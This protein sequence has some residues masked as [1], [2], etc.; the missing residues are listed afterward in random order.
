MFLSDPDALLRRLFTSKQSRKHARLPWDNDDLTGRRATVK[1]DILDLSKDWEKYRSELE[2]KESAEKA[3]RKRKKLEQL[4]AK[5][6][7]DSTPS[8]SLMEQLDSSKTDMQ[9]VTNEA[10]AATTS[11]GLVGTDP[12]N[13]QAEGTSI[14]LPIRSTA[15]S[16][17]AIAALKSRKLYHLNEADPSDTVQIATTSKVPFTDYPNK[18]VNG[19]AA[20]NEAS[21]IRQSDL[22]SID[23]STTCQFSNHELESRLNS[24]IGQNNLHGNPWAPLMDVRGEDYESF[25]KQDVDDHEIVTRTRKEERTVHLKRNSSRMSVTQKKRLRIPST[26]DEASASDSTGPQLPG[27]IQQHSPSAKRHKQHGRS[28]CKEDNRS[29]PLPKESIRSVLRQSPIHGKQSNLLYSGE[30]NSAIDAHGKHIR[31][32]EDDKVI[33]HVE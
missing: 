32:G 12:A 31:F 5:P 8:N 10:P 4:A 3:E 11:F 20:A 28:K 25:D 1:Q 14:N 29:P 21:E 15:I 19:N 23:A 30:S 17:S 7:I 18:Y 22:M 2:K 26:D 33:I 24:A 13:A 6:S 16:E 27:S 9:S